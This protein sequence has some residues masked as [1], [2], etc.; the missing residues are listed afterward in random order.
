MPVGGGEA[1]RRD[2]ARWAR[3]PIEA[4]LTPPRLHAARHV[5]AR[6]RS[7]VHADLVQASLFGSRA[8]GDARPDSDID[9]LLVFRHLPPDREP[10][11]TQAEIIA[12]EEAERLAQPVTVWSVSLDDLR[13]GARTPMLVDAL[14]DAIPL[15][16]A[17]RPL[18]ACPFTP[19]DAVACVAALLR[20]V[21]EGSAEVESMLRMGHVEEAS[22]RVRDDV[23]R[24][25]T[26]HLL[27]HG[28][29]RPRRAEA[30]VAARELVP[31]VP[32]IQR[33]LSWTERSYGPDGISEET[34][35]APPSTGLRDA[36]HA[37]E[38]LRRS[39]RGRR[40]AL[41]ARL[42]RTR[43]GSASSGTFLAPPEGLPTAGY[44]PHR[45][46]FRE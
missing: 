46:E 30:V 8:R 9:I 3:S 39:A 11:A 14:D 22:R 44:R 31:T 37:A 16:T 27:L 38:L 4:V 2:P 21:E 7:E 18:P 33:T 5:V 17:Q 10:Q 15:W 20:R 35:V 23:V 13:R 36:C 34:P 29:T 19:E 1:R 41:A 28:I 12:E 25:C 45:R 26:A 32:A 42:A 24:L 40:T 6:V 43:P